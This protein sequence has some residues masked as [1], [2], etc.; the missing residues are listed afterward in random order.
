MTPFVSN[1]A[2][3]VLNAFDFG[4]YDKVIQKVH[5]KFETMTVLDSQKINPK[6]KACM[7]IP[8]VG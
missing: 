7:N 3:F 1:L 2:P 5:H 6:E 8:Y 4:S